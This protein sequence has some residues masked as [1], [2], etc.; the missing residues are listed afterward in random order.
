MNPLYSTIILCLFGGLAAKAGQDAA[1]SSHLVYDDASF[2]GDLLINEVRVPKDGEAMYTYYEALGWG[3]K[4]AGYAG[5]QA[6]PKGHNF[7]FSIWDHQEHTGPIRAVFRGEGTLTEGFGGEGTGLKSWNFELGWDTD[8]WYTLVA[9]CWPI[10]D[11][12]YYGYWARSDK[13]GRWTHL[14]TMDVAAKEAWMRGGNDSFIEDWLET[15][16]NARTIHLRD[17]WKRHW[18]GKWHAFGSARYSVNHWDLVEGKRSY[19]FRTNWNGGVASDSGGSFYFMTSGGNATKAVT[20][21]PAKFTIERA[22]GEP[23]AKAIRMV[24]GKV[25]PKSPGNAMLRWETDPKT[26][27]QFSIVVTAHDDPEGKG[28]PLFRLEKVEPHARE[29]ELALPEGLDP[30]RVVW[31]LQCRDIFDNQSEL[32]ILRGSR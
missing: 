11:H 1:P 31:R 30:T 2:D 5:I 26:L 21:N 4:A 15:G 16:K 9:R 23:D 10:G 27:P 22:E 25:E 6:H 24:S 19:H 29:I 18:D 7:I 12:T 14:V 28:E 3:G 32:L 20:T 13:T 17:G 8:V